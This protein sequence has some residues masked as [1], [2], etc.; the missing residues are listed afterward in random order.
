MQTLGL[1]FWNTQAPPIDYYFH[2][3][4]C[5]KLEK[6][7]KGF[8]RFQADR[9]M[10]ALVDVLRPRLYAKKLLEFTVILPWDVY[11][12][13]I[14]GPLRDTYHNPYFF[15]LHGI[16]SE[17][18]KYLRKNPEWAGDAQGPVDF[19]LDDQTAKVEGDAAKQFCNVKDTVNTGYARYIGDIAFRND[20]LN[21]PLQA[22]DLIAWQMHRSELG[23]AVDLGGR[24]E[25]RR[26]K[27]A[28]NGRLTRCREDGLAML[29]K[30][31]AE[32]VRTGVW[33]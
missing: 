28:T 1:T 31:V 5:Y 23:L 15:G 8:N 9:K 3:R 17:I 29:S 26:L 33:N 27:A 32:G 16:M 18:A 22:A 14:H 4:E 20:E 19:F 12:R 30:E 11:N 10:N 21:Y 6:Q 2:M 24:R 7:F 25:Y 13:T